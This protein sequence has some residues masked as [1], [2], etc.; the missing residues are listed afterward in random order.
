MDPYVYVKIP[1]VK[2]C[3]KYEPVKFTIC[4]ECMK[5]MSPEFHFI[6]W[7]WSKSVCKFCGTKASDIYPK[8]MVIAS[9]QNNRKCDHK[10]GCNH[11]SVEYKCNLN[12]GTICTQRRIEY[13]KEEK[14]T[15][16]I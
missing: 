12:P 6:T 15:N 5:K 1:D 3:L 14:E 9:I 7:W 10:Y 13:V 4:H 11:V 2:I 8:G 16:S